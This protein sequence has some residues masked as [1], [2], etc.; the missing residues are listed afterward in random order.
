MS[1]R[2]CVLA[3]YYNRHS[4][5]SVTRKPRSRVSR[6]AEGRGERAEGRFLEVDEALK[7]D[8]DR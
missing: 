3:F 8:V 2:V 1:K 5:L 4:Y 7:G 6:E